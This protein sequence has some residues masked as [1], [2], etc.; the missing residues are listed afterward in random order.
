[1]LE[2]L[3]KERSTDLLKMRTK[4]QLIRWTRTFSAVW[5]VGLRPFQ[6]RVHQIRN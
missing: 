3:V 2:H 4:K 5:A 6:F 1:M